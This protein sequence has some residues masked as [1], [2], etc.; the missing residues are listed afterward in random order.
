VL[1][2]SILC[3]ADLLASSAKDF[4]SKQQNLVRNRLDMLVP[5]KPDRASTFNER[6]RLGSCDACWAY[7]RGKSQ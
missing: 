5:G 6:R 3:L 1:G 2:S 7:V 4:S